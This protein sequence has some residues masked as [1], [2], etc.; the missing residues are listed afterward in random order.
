MDVVRLALYVVPRLLRRNTLGTRLCTL[1]HSA[2][3][4]TTNA[5]HT[6]TVVLFGIYIVHQVTLSIVF[7]LIKGTVPN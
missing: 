1:V 5:I 4:Y 6:C 3:C 7:K 2:S